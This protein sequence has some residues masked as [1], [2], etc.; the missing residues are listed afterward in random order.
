M[1]RLYPYSRN[2]DRLLDIHRI[3][4]RYRPGMCQ[5][6]RFGYLCIRH[7]APLSSSLYPCSWV[8]CRLSGVSEEFCPYPIGSPSGVVAGPGFE[9]GRLVRCYALTAI[10]VGGYQI[11]LKGGTESQKVVAPALLLQR[12]P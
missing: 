4:E 8:F 2:P 3:G 5:K 1:N 10:R 6:C 11:F 9:P 12:L 7:A